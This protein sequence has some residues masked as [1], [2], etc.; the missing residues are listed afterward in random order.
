L[1]I[2]KRSVAAPSRSRFGLSEPCYVCSL[3][4]HRFALNLGLLLVFAAALDGQSL[5]VKPVK[6]LGDPNFIGTAANPLNFDS[7]GPNVVEGRELDEPLG[8]ALDTTVSPP[9][10]YIG[11]ERLRT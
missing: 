8:I 3:R 11:R 6:V 2:P 4:A 10:V 1:A 9:I 5:F 7:N